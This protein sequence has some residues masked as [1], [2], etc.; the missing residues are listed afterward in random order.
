MASKGYCN[1]ADADDSNSNR[2]YE[3]EERYDDHTNK[4][5]SVSSKCTNEGEVGAPPKPNTTTTPYSAL[6]VHET[7][8]GSLGLLPEEIVI[9]IISRLSIKV[10]KSSRM[11][12]KT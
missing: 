10:T 12:R 4:T 7:L 5:S 3:D 1:G 6:T 8:S 2:D 9:N 11:T